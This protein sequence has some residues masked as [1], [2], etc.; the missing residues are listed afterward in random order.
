MRSLSILLAIA[1][2][3]VGLAAAYYWWLA[4]RVETKPAWYGVEPVDRVQSQSGWIVGLLDAASRSAKL[5]QKAAVLTGIA[6]L[7][8]TGSGIV[9]L[10]A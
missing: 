2:F 4:S 10:F 5:N 8:S 3:S 1:G 6:I 7:L 9:G